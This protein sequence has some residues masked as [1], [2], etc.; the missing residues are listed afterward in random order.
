MLLDNETLEI[1]KKKYE[2]AV[3][4]KEDIFIF[5]EQEIYTTYAKYLIEY[6]ENFR[7]EKQ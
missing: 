2:Q 1:F 4:D 7:K 6:N 5:L 3:E